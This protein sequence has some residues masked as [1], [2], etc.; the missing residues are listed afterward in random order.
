M[1][2]RRW[3]KD[4]ADVFDYIEAFYNRTGRHCNWSFNWKRRKFDDSTSALTV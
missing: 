1:A 2:K 4:R 3:I